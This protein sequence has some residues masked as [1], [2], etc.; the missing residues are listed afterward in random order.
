MATHDQMRKK[1]A[2]SAIQKRIHGLCLIQFS[3]RAMPW[4]SITKRVRLEEKVSTTTTALVALYS[5]ISRGI[6]V[7]AL[8]P[9]P[10][11][12]DFLW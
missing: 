9:R 1:T 4:Y 8:K 11:V 7:S 6:G 3:C 5:T 10:A 2:P 12:S